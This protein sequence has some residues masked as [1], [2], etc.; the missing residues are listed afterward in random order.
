MKK[1]KLSSLQIGVKELLT[2]EQMKFV[3]GGSGDGSGGSGGSG[4][5]GQCVTVFGSGSWGSGNSCYYTTSSPE[6]LCTRVYG[7]DC[8]GVT[9]QGDN[10]EGCTMN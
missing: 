5:T 9:P 2:R 3:Y 1:L 10:C 7:N 8:Y 4:G 6:D